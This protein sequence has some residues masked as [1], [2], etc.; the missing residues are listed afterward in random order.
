MWQLTDDQKR[1]REEIRAVVREK[2]QPR[3]REIDEN[4]EY[5]RDLYEVM[6][7]EGLLN[8]SVPKAYGG[9]CESDVSWCAYVEELA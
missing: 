1:L 8:L 3:A 4:C 9:R 5:P 2:I 6:S 7:D